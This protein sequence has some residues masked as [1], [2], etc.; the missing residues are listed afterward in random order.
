MNRLI[1]VFIFLIALQAFSLRFL[2]FGEIPPAVSEALTGRVVTGIASFLSVPLLIYLIAQLS[3]D[4]QLG[5]LSGFWLSILPWS[6]EQGRINS[7]YPLILLILL[8]FLLLFLKTSN[9]LL[10][11]VL[12]LVALVLIFILKPFWFQQGIIGQFK[13]NSILNNFF[14]QLS[15]DFLFFKN[16]S[17]WKGGLRNY[18]IIFPEAIPIFLVGLYLLIQRTKVAIY[19]L[20][21]LVLLALIG[22]LNSQFPEDRTLFLG[23]P[24]LALI[25]AFGTKKLSEFLKSQSKVIRIISIFYLLVLF[26]GLLQFTHFYLVH[27]NL[28]IRQERLYESEKF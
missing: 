26:Y 28:Q 20:G 18:G 4:W 3:K 12:S 16:D 23:T 1:K 15:F 27:Y 14:K 10:K 5:F 7:P 11:S 25:L 9:K 2:G 17:F 13:I 6:L 24:V 22:S 19:T 21:W 8:T